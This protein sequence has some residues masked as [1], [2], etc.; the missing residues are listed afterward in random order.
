[1]SVRKTL[2]ALTAAALAM[3]ALPARAAGTLVATSRYSL[4]FP[5]GWTL[6]TITQSD[7]FKFV[8]NQELG[9]TCYTASSITDH[10]VTAP[11]IAAAI[12]QYGQTDSVT[13]TTDGAKT[14]GGKEFSYIEYRNTDA[15]DSTRAR[16]YYVSSGNL[17][18]TAYTAYTAGG[19][20]NTVVTQVEAA[21]ATLTLNANTALRRAGRGDAGSRPADHDLMGRLR[22]GAARMA[23]FRLPSSR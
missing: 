15:S 16:F 9:A 3:A 4:T 1:M 6:F 13:K 18:F 21:L 5:E 19:S 10:P 23:L 12:R 17:L 8:I 22:P 11:E 14:L 7:S 20:G 2:F